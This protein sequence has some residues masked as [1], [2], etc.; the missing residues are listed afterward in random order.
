M[1]EDTLRGHYAGFV[2][3]FTAFII[4]L[5]IIT[6]ISIVVGWTISRPLLLIGIDVTEPCIN[7]DTSSWLSF[8]QTIWCLLAKISIPITAF[9]VVIGYPLILWTLT[10]QTIG[11]YALGVRVVRMDGRPLSFM[12]AVRRLFGY[13]I[14]LLFL[15]FGFFWIL[16]SNQRQ[17]WH[18]KIA[19]TCVIYAWDAR[20][21]E[22][23]SGRIVRIANRI[24]ARRTPEESPPAFPRE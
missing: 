2:S 17:G 4:D 22:R 18:D 16:L 24:S 20:E 1:S 21:S 3:R 15:G 23:F 11:K 10:G 8:F 19:G 12:N 14:S 9:L 13:F 7:V 6:L 5:V